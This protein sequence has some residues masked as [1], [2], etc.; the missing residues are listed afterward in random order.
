MTVGRSCAA[1]GARTWHIKPWE[2]EQ[3]SSGVR[4]YY[5]VAVHVPIECEFEPNSPQESEFG[6]NSHLYYILCE[7]LYLNCEIWV[8]M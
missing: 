3:K 5:I 6:S 1:A 2:G 8:K 7:I 4:L